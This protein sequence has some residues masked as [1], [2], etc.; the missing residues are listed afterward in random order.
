MAE[1]TKVKGG[2]IFQTSKMIEPLFAPLKQFGITYFSYT[3]LYHNGAR[4]DINNH[5]SMSEYYYVRSGI[6]QTS[7]LESD[8][9][10]LNNGLLLWSAFP[11]D[12]SI[13]I[14]REEFNT[15]NGI[16][17]VENG[18]DFT[19]LWHFAS[20]NENKPILNFFLNNIDIL[21]LFTYHFKEKAHNLIESSERKN[22]TI[23]TSDTIDS[24]PEAS[25]I[26]LDK[27][28]KDDYEKALDIN[29]YYL[30]GRHDGIYLTKKEIEC[31]KWSAQGK[32]S[33]EI[34]I[35]LASS[36]RTVDVHLNNIKN[37]L[38]LYK[39]TQ[40]TRKAIDLGIIK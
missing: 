27:I 3:R 9:L 28:N 32:A 2:I 1:V 5:P 31:L 18:Y 8:P 15:D 25:P 30:N 7:A 13:I 20:T 12:E 34:G 11:N 10:S 37:K 38:G 33:D 21:K 35:L 22:V 14:A 40:L 19:E 39:Q 16:T 24:R 17:M 6:Y 26:L 29:R 36:S 4:I 23:I